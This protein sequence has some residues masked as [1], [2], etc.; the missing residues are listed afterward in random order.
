ME[1][2]ATCIL[3]ILGV[4]IVLSKLHPTIHVLR[5]AGDGQSG[6]LIERALV[7]ACWVPMNR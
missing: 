2:D 6:R 4:S 3:G 7:L 1:A 5:R